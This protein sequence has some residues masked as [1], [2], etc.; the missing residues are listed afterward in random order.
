MDKEELAS[1]EQKWLERFNEKDTDAIEEYSH[2]CTRLT[3][4][5]LAAAKEDS[6][7]CQILGK[8]LGYPWFKDDRKNFPEAT[9]LD[10]VCTGDHVAITIVEEAAKCIADLEHRL[11]IAE[12]IIFKNT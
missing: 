4:I 9:E 5:V 1:F 10:G 12:D 8:A 6:E 11:A 3:D 2:V 7:I